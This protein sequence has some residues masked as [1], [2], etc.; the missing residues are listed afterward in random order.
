MRGCIHTHKN[1]DEKNSKHCKNSVKDNHVTSKAKV[2]AGLISL[3]H[4]ALYRFGYSQLS[5][6]SCEPIPSNHS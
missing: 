3:L 4:L 1:G 2:G 5:G 6:E